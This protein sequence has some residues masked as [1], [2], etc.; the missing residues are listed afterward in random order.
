GGPRSH[1]SRGAGDPAEYRTRHQA[2]AARIVEVEDTA[3]ELT[4]RI[5]AGD[6]DKVVIH[7]LGSLRIDAEAAK[8]ECDA[9]ADLIGFKG[10]PVDCVRPVRLGNLEADGAT[11]VLCRGVEG[12]VRLN[13]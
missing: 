13:G 4:C 6:G 11:T 2:G 8:C 3:D 12:Y 5:E 10:R 7:H 1:R 9:A